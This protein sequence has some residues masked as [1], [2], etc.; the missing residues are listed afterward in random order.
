M[1][2]KFALGKKWF[3]IGVVVS[4]LHPV[5]GIIYA[6]ALLTDG[7]EKYLKEALIIALVGIVWTIITY[8]WIAPWL[9]DMNLLPK[10]TLPSSLK[11]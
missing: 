5:A 9:R 10:Y 1:E 11:Y 6:I 4:F 7:K 2:D 3:W 8:F